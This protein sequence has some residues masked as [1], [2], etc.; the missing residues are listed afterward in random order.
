MAGCV[1]KCQL[2]RVLVQLG[3]ADLDFLPPFVLHLAHKHV[4]GL[5]EVLLLEQRLLVAVDD[6]LAGQ[7]VVEG[8]AAQQGAPELKVS[9][10]SEE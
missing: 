5:G 2:R 10:L 7:P 8:L 9:N 6:V 1:A 3:A 4:R